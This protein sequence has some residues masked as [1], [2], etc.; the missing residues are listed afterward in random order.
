MLFL[1][2]V[3]KITKLKSIHFFYCAILVNY[4][5]DKARRCRGAMPRDY[6]GNLLKEINPNSYDVKLN[7][8][9]GISYEY[10]GYDNKIKTIYPDGSIERTKYDANGNV[11]KRIA[12]EQYDKELDD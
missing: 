5:Y 6:E 11:I 3:K 1:V 7:D 12:P 9:E 4:I 2:E 10:D 8:G